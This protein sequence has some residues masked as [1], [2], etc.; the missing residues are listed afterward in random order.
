MNQAGQPTII[1]LA[2][3]V[4][5]VVIEIILLSKYCCRNTTVEIL[6]HASREPY[7]YSISPPDPSLQVFASQINPLQPKPR[8]NFIII[9]TRSK[10]IG[11]IMSVNLEHWFGCVTFD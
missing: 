10:V 4:L 1:L 3:P 6:L 7:H 11:N 8:Q 2:Y 5:V 9:I